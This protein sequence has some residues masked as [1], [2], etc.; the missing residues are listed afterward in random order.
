MTYASN[1]R[2]FGFSD[3]PPRLPDRKL[4]HLL[5]FRHFTISLKY[6]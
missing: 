6:R 4:F 1:P 3:F 5:G 2:D